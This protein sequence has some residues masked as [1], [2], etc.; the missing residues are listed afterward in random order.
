MSLA[1]K[2]LRESIKVLLALF[3]AKLKS[4]FEVEANSE[5]GSSGWARYKPIMCDMCKAYGRAERLCKVVHG[6]QV[7]AGE[8]VW[9]AQ[10]YAQEKRLQ[11]LPKQTSQASGK[12]G[13]AE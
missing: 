7:Q 4:A 13:F 6:R 5:G 12:K 10:S 3:L 11:K 2:N 8:G 9:S 1:A